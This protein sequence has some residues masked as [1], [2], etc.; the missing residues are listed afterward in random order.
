ML[1]NII[2]VVTCN[3]ITASD[4]LSNYLKLKNISR[5]YE[6]HFFLKQIEPG[7]PVI[8]TLNNLVA[9]LIKL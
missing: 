7:L 3:K 5:K 6:V 9:S 4:L 1:E 8:D 2:G